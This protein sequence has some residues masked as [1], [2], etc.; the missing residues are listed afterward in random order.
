M[1]IDVAVSDSALKARAAAIREAAIRR[2]AETPAAASL[3]A[4]RTRAQCGDAAVPLVLGSARLRGARD[5]GSQERP[6][7]AQMHSRDPQGGDGLH[8]PATPA[9]GRRRATPRDVRR[10]L[11][12]LR[13]PPRVELHIGFRDL[14][15]AR[16]ASCSILRSSSERGRLIWETVHAVDYD[17][18]PLHLR[19]LSTRAKIRA[20]HAYWFDTRIPLL[21]ELDG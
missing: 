20:P 4:R 19:G 8:S 17:E 9:G 11:H 14:R 21:V 15:R 16:R 18:R 12:T 7:T 6:P 3:R 2:G 1:G 5:D 13:A 10:G